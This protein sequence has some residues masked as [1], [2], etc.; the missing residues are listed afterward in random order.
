MFPRE[1]SSWLSGMGSLCVS[2][3]VSNFWLITTHSLEFALREQGCFYI[4]EVDN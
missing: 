1:K 2:R 3:D 4:H